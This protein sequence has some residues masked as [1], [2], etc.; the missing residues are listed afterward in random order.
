M[1]GLPS[2]FEHVAQHGAERLVG[3]MRPESF[4]ADT[5]VPR[6]WAASASESP[7]PLI[8]SKATRCVSGSPRAELAAD[9]GGELLRLHQ[10]VGGGIERRA[11]VL[12][13]RLREDLAPAA[14]EAVDH[15]APRD[16]EGP[17]E[18]LGPGD[19]APARPMNL[20][21]RLLENVLRPSGVARLPH[22]VAVDAGGELVV[23]RREGRLF[24]RSVARH[25]RVACGER[26]RHRVRE[27]ARRG[28]SCAGSALGRFVSPVGA[29]AGEPCGR[30]AHPRTEAYAA[31]PRAVSLA[32]ARDRR[33]SIRGDYD[34]DRSLR[35]SGSRPEGMSRERHA[36]SRAEYERAR[37]QHDATLRVGSEAIAPRMLSSSRSSMSSPLDPGLLRTVPSSDTTR[38]ACEHADRCGGCPIIALPYNEQLALKRGRVVQSVARYPAL[39]LVYTEPVAAADP[40]VAYR[41]RAK[42]IVGLGGKVGLFAKGGGHQ[43]VDIPNCRVISP[44]L[45]KVAEAMRARSLADAETGG[46]LAPFDP[47][48]GGSLRALDLREVRESADAPPKVL[49]TWVVQRSRTTSVDALRAAAERLMTELPEVLGVS[50][51]FHE[52]EAP[53]ILGSETILLAG[54]ASARDALGASVHLATYGSFVQ[55]HRGQATRVHAVLAES[56]GLARIARRQAAPAAPRPLGG[57]GR[58]RARPGHHRRDGPPRRVVRARGRARQAGGRVAGVRVTAECGDVATVARGLVERAE[59]FDAAVVNPPRRGM[60]PTAREWLARL[61]PAAIAYVSCDPDTLARDLDHL[62]RLGYATSELRPLDMIP[63]TDEVE[64]I[65]LLRRSPVPTPRV[66]YED[67]EVIIVEKGAHEPTSPQSEYAGSLLARARKIPNAGD[68]VPVHRIDIGTSGLVIL[69]RRGEVV[70]RWQEALGSATTRKIYVAAT[71]GVTPSKG[72]ITRELREDGKMYPARTRY[73][74]LAV[75]SGHSVVRVIPEQGRTHQIRR[76]LA[77]IGHPVL[78]DDRYGHVPTN[79]FFEEKNGLDRAFLH[80]VRIELDHPVTGTRLIVEAPLPGDLRAVLERTS[81]PGTLR[82]LDHKNALGTSGSLSSLPPPPDSTHERGSVLDVDASSPTIHPEAISGDDDDSPDRNSGAF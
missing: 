44:P 73:R 50:V 13:L 5:V 26:S 25:R 9:A 34:D 10:V 45:A 80:C 22:E 7:S 2:R 3:A 51:N 77:A 72:A 79:R 19:E 6:T 28:T 71:R 52:G 1:P 63:L 30:T 31:P 78:G 64:T 15:Q 17:R 32:A 11:I 41:T 54:V 61:E 55:A 57:L 66:A 70:N 82:F 59:R 62:L 43:V 39:E 60:G 76:H 14:T 40:I 18:D 53:Q 16:R 29:S 49:V 56:L 48:G 81:G 46:T 37:T 24:A 33:P 65:A 58:D 35:V 42:M 75:A 38:V 47:G 67:D 68:A 36:V 74:R 12:R 20:E 27:Q 21:E 69:A 4:T 23:H 8:S